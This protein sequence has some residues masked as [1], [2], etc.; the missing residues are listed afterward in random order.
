MFFVAYTL[1]H[2]E[3]TAY[4]SSFNFKEV[5]QLQRGHPEWGAYSSSLLSG[6]HTT[7]RHG[8]DAGV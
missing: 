6:G 1:S 8:H 4:P 3:S 2:T 5:L 7:P